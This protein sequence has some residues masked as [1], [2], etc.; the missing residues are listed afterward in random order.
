MT[1]GQLELLIT[2]T[3]VHILPFNDPSFPT[4]IPLSIISTLALGPKF[5]PTPMAGNHPSVA[6]PLLQESITDVT[7]LLRFKE[8]F[9]GR[10][11]NEPIP[12]FYVPNKNAKPIIGRETTTLERGISE[13]QKVPMNLTPPSYP[14]AA[15]I[16]RRL[17]IQLV[18]FQENNPATLFRVCDKNLGIAIIS[19]DWYTHT[20]NTM[21]ADSTTYTPIPAN[22]A[23]AVQ[24]LHSNYVS[25][26]LIAATRRHMQALRLTRPPMNSVFIRAGLDNNPPSMA[27]I[28]IFHG[29]VKLHKTPTALRPIVAAHSTPLTNLNR[30]LAYALQPAVET[31]PRWIQSSTHLLSSLLTLQLPAAENGK[32]IWL[33]T[34]DVAS[35][36]TNIDTQLANQAVHHAFST[37]LESRRRVVPLSQQEAIDVTR[38][39]LLSN[40]F[41]ASTTQHDITYYRQTKGLAMGNPM[42]PPIAN[43]VMDALENSLSRENVVF[44]KRYIDDI[45]VIL[46]CNRDEATDFCNAYNA[47]HEDI[48]IEWSP[49]STEA[50]FLDL[51]LTYDPSL[52]RILSKTHQKILNAYLYIPY[53]SFHTPAMKLSFI[54]AELERYA[55]NS[56]TIEAFLV[57]RTLFWARLRKRGY[58][59]FFLKK[60]FLPITFTP[61]EE[62]LPFTLHRQ[63][64]Q[65]PIALK[66][67]YLPFFRELTMGR[68]LT[69][70]PHLKTWLLRHSTPHRPNPLVLAWKRPPNL[71]TL[72]L[73]SDHTKSLPPTHPPS[74]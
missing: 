15:N 4:H 44:W 48:N 56:S 46:Y 54:R 37:C 29:I 32:R 43:L 1:P 25:K 27:T 69:L 17:Q 51:H 24:R 47:L 13:L 28:P 3:G 61:P 9:A 41:K 73:K 18:R 59:T 40:V 71:G 62:R 39:S 65:A 5:I 35:L 57:T 14:S 53:K 16:S 33:L 64:R 67:P 10:E 38:R 22:R 66:L 30:L 45:L 12:R 23:L 36:Y 50:E 74:S 8:M 31:S 26:T 6:L 72:I 70:T 63:Q 68:I 19:R 49:P 2:N 42:A 21:L 52:R 11:N 34:G 7:R 55:R 60:A 20:V 58:P